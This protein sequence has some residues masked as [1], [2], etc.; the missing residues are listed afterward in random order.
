MPCDC[1]SD[2]VIGNPNWPDVI[3]QTQLVDAPKGPANPSNLAA[4]FPVEGAN[5]GPKNKIAAL[6]HRASVVSHSCLAH[7]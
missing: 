6:H 3:R 5:A 2:D 7:R 1:R 4:T